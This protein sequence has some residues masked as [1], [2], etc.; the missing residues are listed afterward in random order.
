MGVSQEET[1]TPNTCDFDV[2]NLISCA[3]A[4]I[5][6]LIYDYCGVINEVLVKRLPNSPQ[7]GLSKEPPWCILS[8]NGDA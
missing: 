1:Y 4:D 7:N 3:P 2:L 6:G 5:K 8:F